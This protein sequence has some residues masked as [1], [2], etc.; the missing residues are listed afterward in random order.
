M[1]F[2]KSKKYHNKDGWATSFTFRNVYFMDEMSPPQDE[3]T[4]PERLAEMLED[5]PEHMHI[6]RH[7]VRAKEHTKPMA[8]IKSLVRTDA[9]LGMHNHFPFQ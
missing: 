3:E 1:L 8:Y 7:V 6:L 2:S 5:I 4:P 9:V